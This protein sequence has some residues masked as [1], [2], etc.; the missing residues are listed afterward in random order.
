VPHAFPF[1][2]AQTPVS[3]PATTAAAASNRWRISFFL[4][5]LHTDVFVIVF[6]LP[7]CW[8]VS[9][10]FTLFASMSDSV[11]IAIR[12]SVDMLFLENWRLTA[13]GESPAIFAMSFFRMECLTT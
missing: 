3:I 9:M 4:F 1:R 10:S 13:C 5:S 11:T 6:L 8:M 12:T 7:Y 2:I